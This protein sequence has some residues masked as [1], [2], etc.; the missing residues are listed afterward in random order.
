MRK[1]VV[2][3]LVFMSLAASVLTAKAITASSVADN[4]WTVKAPIQTPR[5]CLGVTAVNGKLYAIGGSNETGFLASLPG[6][7][8]AWFLSDFL[9][10]NEEYDSATDTWTYKTAMPTP[11]IAF[12]IAVYQNKIYCI[13]GKTNNGLTG[14]NEVYDPATDT[15][16]TKTPMPTPR[17]WL[18]A[19]VLNGSIY[20]VGGYSPISVQLNEVYNPETDSWSTKT[21]APN[22]LIFGYNSAASAVFDNK[23][24]FIPGEPEGDYNQI[25]DA[26]TDKWSLGTSSPSG[27]STGVAVAT[28][29]VLAPEKIYVFDYSNVRVYDP[30]NESWKLGADMLT[31]SRFNF[32]AAILNDTIY[33]VGGYTYSWLPGNYAAV[34]TNEQYT[35]FGYG[36]IPLKPEPEAFPLTLV[37]V[38]FVTSVTIITM[39]LLIYFKKREKAKSGDEA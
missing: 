14:I 39:I 35:P 16:E 1:S 27:I 3:L 5:S 18:K 34:A 19:N 20:L 24:Y 36:T 33:V 13:G 2:V 37:A 38:A 4:T 31:K 28:T 8:L 29:G 26:E 15:W 12:A 32:G 23:I 6:A 21:P 30:E 25:Y 9:D 10:T 11:R 7:D 22:S 17:G